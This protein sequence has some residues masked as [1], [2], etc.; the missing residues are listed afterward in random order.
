MPY[1]IYIRYV[2]ERSKL[3]NQDD[4]EQMVGHFVH[5][6]QCLIRVNEV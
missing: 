6:Q 5:N 3:P 1:F 2:G 4:I